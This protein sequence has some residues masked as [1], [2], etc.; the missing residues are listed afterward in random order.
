M[1]S[2][3][4]VALRLSTLYAA[5]FFGIG[6][7]SPFLPVWFRGLGLSP[8]QIALLVAAPLVVRILASV[9]TAGL[10]DGRA[11][12]GRILVAA[13]LLVGLGYLAAAPGW[14]FPVLLLLTASIALA[15]SPI[16]PLSDVLAIEAA[17][18]RPRL[19]YGRIRVWGSLSFTLATLLAG[20]AVGW[21]G[22]GVVPLA[23]G[24]SY[25]GAAAAAL[26]VADLDRDDAPRPAQ[27][28]A[29][30]V[31]LPGALVL[32][33]LSAAMIHSSHSMM[34][35]F[36]SISFEA[37]GVSP[38]GVGGLWAVTVVVEVALFSLMGRVGGGRAPPYGF[39]CVGGAA[40]A[41]RWIGMGLEPGP[42]AI[43]LLQLLHG[44]SF[45][46]TH[47]GTIGAFASLAPAAAKARLQGA[48]VASISLASALATVASGPLYG[49]FGARAFLAMAPVAV[50]GLV[51]ALA[52]W[53]LAPQPQS[54][55]EGGNTSPPS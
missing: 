44:A 48:L 30:R 31:R 15:Q 13:N 29:G 4:S 55:R 3:T 1:R 20:A 25:L 10:A 47:L 7:S 18:S 53:R 19:H 34:N 6:V 23:L 12:A 50:L 9:W 37:A 2:D 35:A 36:G 28:S 40:A 32:V 51:F 49:G 24:A 27:P 21:L 45:G 42:G 52:A 43:A 5:T 8:D 11:P 16:I 38:A 41:L 22:S 54:A 46:A 26:L 14:A 33:I 39:L 17:K